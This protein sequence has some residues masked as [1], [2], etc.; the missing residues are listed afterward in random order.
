MHQGQIYDHTKIFSF[1][2]KLVLI[3]ISHDKSV[4]YLAKLVQSCTDKETP[5]SLKK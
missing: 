4:F 1:V 2:V 3:H 5:I